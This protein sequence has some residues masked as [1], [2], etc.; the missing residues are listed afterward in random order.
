MKETEISLKWKYKLPEILKKVQTNLTW[1]FG[2]PEVLQRKKYSKISN[3]RMWVTES[4]ILWKWI[5]EFISG[6]L[7]Y[8][9]PKFLYCKFKIKTK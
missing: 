7:K 4:F 5:F 3:Y 6:F 8:K 1:D 2:N 9:F